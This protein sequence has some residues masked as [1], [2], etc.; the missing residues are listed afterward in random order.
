MIQAPMMKVVV[1]TIMKM[2]HL[3]T[4]HKKIITIFLIV[5]SK[6]VLLNTDTTQVIRHYTTG[7][8]K[9]RLE[10]YSLIDQ[11]KILF[12]QRLTTNY[13][14]ATPLLSIAVVPPATSSPIPPL[15]QNWASQKTKQNVRFNDKQKQYVE[16]KFHEDVRTGSKL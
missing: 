10:K 13:S 6:V 2:N 15:G 14:R 4:T 5:W 11:S 7:K 16:E 12:H 9:L 1:M 3:Q 8:H